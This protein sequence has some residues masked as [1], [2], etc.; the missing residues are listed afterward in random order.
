[1]VRKVGY[2]TID[3][4]PSEDFRNKVKHLVE[5][6]IPAIFFCR[7][8]YLVERSEDVIL[9]IKKGFVIGNHSYNHARF[10]EIPLKE[11]FHQIK[12]TDERPKVS[13]KMFSICCPV[14]G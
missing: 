11:C 12:Q 13:L 1:M 10:S 8:D 7:G 3:D 6:E 5:K 14:F 4:A 9:A 2:L